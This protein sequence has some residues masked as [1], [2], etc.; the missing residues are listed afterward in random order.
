ME[1]IEVILFLI[2][3]FFGIDPGR[4]IAED[5]TVTIDTKHQ[6]IEI[7]Q[8]GFFSIIQD[9]EDS[10]LTY[11]QWNRLKSQDTIT[12][13]TAL[14]SFT[15][16]EFKWLKTAKNDSL[17]VFQ[18]QFNMKYANKTMLRKLGVWYNAETAAFSINHIPQQNIS[19]DNGKLEENFWIF[20]PDEQGKF[21]FRL[22]PFLNLPDEFEIFKIRL[23]DK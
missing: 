21:S 23:D 16:K 15:N 20:T 1:Q 22:Q 19:T 18:A 4:I 12:W 13:S 6:E 9:V 7:I 17:E 10:T 2:L 3:S 5:S 14:D 11:P 8:N